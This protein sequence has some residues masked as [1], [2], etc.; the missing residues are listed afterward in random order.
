LPWIGCRLTHSPECILQR[1]LVVL[2]HRSVRRDALAVH[3]HFV[4][5]AHRRSWKHFV[6]GWIVIY[7]GED[8]LSSTLQ[9]MWGLDLGMSRIWQEFRFNCFY[10]HFTLDQT[11]WNQMDPSTSIGQPPGPR[12]GH[13]LITWSSQ[14][15]LFG[16]STRPDSS[17]YSYDLLGS[18]LFSL[19][20]VF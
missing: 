15:V 17:V 12:S 13:S 1:D 4:G 9:D 11:N 18:K 10:S 14:V 5:S 19:S 7:G 20:F 3:H 6:G 2:P 8:N 16:G